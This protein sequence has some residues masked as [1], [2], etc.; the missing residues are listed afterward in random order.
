MTNMPLTPPPLPYTHTAGINGPLST[1]NY[2]KTMCP[3]ATVVQAFADSLY[4][5]V[6]EVH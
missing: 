1:Q 3:G 5:L 4:K 6:I 2:K